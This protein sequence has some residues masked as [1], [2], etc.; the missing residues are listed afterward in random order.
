MWLLKGIRQVNWPSGS[1]GG[2]PPPHLAKSRISRKSWIKYFRGILKWERSII[3]P[4]CHNNMLRH[5]LVVDWDAV[6]DEAL[7]RVWQVG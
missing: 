3:A 1:G 6:V 2:I 7:C 4:D 5:L